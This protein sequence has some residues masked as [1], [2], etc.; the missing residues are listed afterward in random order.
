MMKTYSFDPHTH[1]LNERFLIL[2]YKDFKPW[3][4]KNPAAR[5]TVYVLMLLEKGE[6]D[7]SIGG[8]RQHIKAPAVLSGVPGDV[9]HWH[10]RN[11]LEITSINF[12]A[13]SLLA[14]L[15]GQF[16]L[17]PISFLS[18]DERNPF[19]RLSEERF[20]RLKLLVDD[21]KECLYDRPV[22]YDLLRCQLFQFIFLTEKEYLINDNRSRKGTSKNTGA[23]FLA[24]VNRHYKTRHDVQ[25]YADQLNVSPN[26]LNKLSKTNLGASAKD[27]IFN[28][29]ISEARLLLR[30]TPV[31]VNELAYKLGFNDP[32]YFIR[33]FKKYCGITPKEFQNQGTL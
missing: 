9:W 16:S 22:F 3:I 4:D 15:Q 23:H 5:K 6:A 10:E 20:R 12:E 17:D 7:V 11:G 28:R 1:P 26:Y 2:G 25:F 18:A 8:V 13:A 19:I 14:A 24:L 27:F 21:M 32:N 33:C 30:L 31:N 29:I